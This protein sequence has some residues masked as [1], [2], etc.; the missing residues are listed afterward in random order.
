MHMLAAV[1][2]NA[3]EPFA[4]ETLEIEEPREDELLIRVAAA[5]LSHIDLLAR[6]G[7][8]PVPLPAVL[9]REAAGRVER[10]GAAVTRFAPGDHV[11]LTY[12]A[13]SLPSDASNPRDGADVLNLNCS[14]LR[15]D[16]SSP[17]RLNGES[18]AGAFFG[19]SSFAEHAL[20][21]ERNAVR[22]PKDIPF[23][24]LAP[25]GG[26][27]QS[28]AG[29]VINTLRPRPG[30]A[31]AIFGAGPIGLSA[32]MAARLTGCHPIIAVDIKATRLELAEAVGATHSIDPDGLDPVHAIRKIT[33]QGAEYA[34]ETTGRPDVAR[35]AIDCLAE[36]GAAALT[37]MTL[38]GAEAVIALNHLLLRR[39]VCGSLFGD[40]VPPT[41]LPQLIEFFR[42]GRFPIDRI[43]SEY[44]LDQINQAA[45]DS[46]SGAAVQP[47]LTMP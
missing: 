36:G 33:A 43:I 41:F 4:I 5:G 10:V 13:D 22:V 29:A 21:R 25:L 39:T 16:G 23:P 34:I 44:R 9:G 14:G 18:I 32:V 40:G 6:D 30:C 26:D 2:R 47:V 35:Q 42:Q 1:A 17:L 27:L 8:L 12:L 46:L 24:I 45:D 37:E 3:R 15:P 19:Q 31:I 20:A 7:C 11:V 38:P 28:G